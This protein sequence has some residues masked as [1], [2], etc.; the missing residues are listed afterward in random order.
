MNFTSA[1]AVGVIHADGKPWLNQNLSD[2][3][4]ATYMSVQFDPC[5]GLPSSC[6]GLPSEGCCQFHEG[7]VAVPGNS[8]RIPLGPS[9]RNGFPTVDNLPGTSALSGCWL[10]LPAQTLPSTVQY[11][12]VPTWH[13][14]PETRL[15]QFM[16]KI[17]QLLSK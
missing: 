7:S 15:T 12:P 10:F 2:T 13:R 11:P 1:R 9:D 6:V 5:L 17:S 16:F 4:L 14:T 3:A 8:P